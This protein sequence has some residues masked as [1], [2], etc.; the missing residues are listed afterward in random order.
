MKPG[1]YAIRWPT[2]HEFA[3]F[4]IEE[5]HEGKELDMHW[6]PITKF[7]TPCQ[8]KFDVIAK[9]ETLDED[10][11]Y[12]IHKAGLTHL[13]QP[14]RKNIGKGKNTT[15]LMKKYYSMLTQRQIHEIYNLFKYDFELFGYHPEAFFDMAQADEFQER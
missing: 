11:Q 9:F 15:E 10:Q 5:A 7:C 8:V 4:L 1:K 6:T 13:I 3:D 2:F 14:Q 12:L